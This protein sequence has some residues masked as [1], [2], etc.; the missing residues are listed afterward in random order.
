M[1]K[2]KL[3]QLIDPNINENDMFN[4]VRYIGW[5]SK[6]LIYRLSI[7][8][9]DTKSDM[10][11]KHTY[12]NRW[13]QS[14]LNINSKPEIEL[15]LE[16]DS[17]EEIKLLEI[18]YIK[19]YKELGYKL[20]NTTF[21]GDGQLGR[22]VPDSQK[23]LFEKSVDVYSKDGIYLNSIKSITE[24]AKLYNTNSGKVSNVCNGIRKT[25]KGYVFRFSGEPFDK[26]EVKSN[27]GKNSKLKIKIYEIDVNNNI[28]KE[29]DSIGECARIENLSLS[30]LKMCIKNPFKKNGQRRSCSDRFFIKKDIV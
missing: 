2:I 14:L 24:A 16:S 9:N 20:T 1:G 12:K 17:E 30:H 22:V 19:E 26:Y 4:R 5:T 13:I 18:K 8:I 11:Q 6:S 23:A 25:S 28:L 21:G 27:K 3:Y 29:F 15:I 7:H 10:T